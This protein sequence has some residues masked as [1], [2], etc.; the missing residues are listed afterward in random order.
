[1]NTKKITCYALL[2]ALSLIL[3][4]LENLL[5]SGLF[6]PGV[7][8]G[9]SNIAVVCVL[10]SFGPLPALA[11]GLAKSF[12]SLLLFGRLSGLLYSAFGIIFAVLTMALVKKTGIF[13]LFGVG[14]SG[15]AAHIFGQ[16]VA[17]CIMLSSV[18]PLRLF[19]VLCI[20]SMLC[21]AV[22]YYPEYT[23]LSFIRKSG[24]VEQT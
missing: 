16:L 8:L 22:L 5:F 3:S 14:I 12:I 1:M 23:I 19:P 4:Y 17:S 7:K 10:Y 9:L 6:L 20:I 15:S 11:L 18:H 21:A 13:S 24:L 2:L